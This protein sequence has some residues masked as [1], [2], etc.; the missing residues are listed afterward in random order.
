MMKKFNGSHDRTIKI[1]SGECS[2]DG[3]HRYHY[4]PKNADPFCNGL[5]FP[6]GQCCQAHIVGRRPGRARR[7][8]QKGPA[9]EPAV[10]GSNKRLITNH[11]GINVVANSWKMRPCI[12]APSRLH[13]W[14]SANA[15]SRA[16][17]V[18]IGNRCK[19]SDTSA[20]KNSKG[21]VMPSHQSHFKW[22]MRVFQKA[23]P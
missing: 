10:T 12:G 20:E 14:R 19:G 8:P 23:N 17:E 2:E 13:P 6:G 9:C 21:G 5:E 1:A 16:M 4:R 22:P 15:R 11:T 18:N 7:L 3:Y